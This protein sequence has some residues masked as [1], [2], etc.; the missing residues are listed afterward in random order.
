MRKYNIPIFIPHEGCPHDCLFCSQRKITGVQS[1]VTPSDAKRLIGEYLSTIPNTDCEIEIAYFGG[2]FTGLDLSLQREFLAA[3]ASFSDPRITGIRMST[4]PDYITGEILDQCAEFGVNAIELGVQSTDDRI[5]ML[6]RR[7]HDFYDVVHAADM[8]KA[9]GFELGLQMMLGMYGSTPETDIKTCDDIIALSPKSTR[10]YPTLVLS[11]TDLERLYN[12]G[13]YTPY[14][15]ETALSAAADCLERFRSSDIDVL[16]VGLYSSDE[17]RAD[18]NIVSG[19]FHPAFG[20]LTENLIYRR[21]IEKEIINRGLH[22]CVYEIA[23]PSSEISKIIGQ[24]KSNK[25][26]FKENYGVELKLV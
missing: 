18:G 10:I 8:I 22:D 5:L 11:G 24:K 26:Y 14:S 12:S 4:R 15:L 16:R 3:A 23:A 17:L 1:S 25:I 7:G 9:Y 19:P 21:K 6:N 20:E 2:S 13:E